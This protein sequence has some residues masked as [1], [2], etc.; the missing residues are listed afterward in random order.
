MLPQVENIREDAYRAFNAQNFRLAIQESVK[1]ITINPCSAWPYFLI[2]LS[3][4]SLG[5]P[6]EAIVYLERYLCLDTARFSQNKQRASRIVKQIKN[7]TDG[8]SKSR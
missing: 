8:F 2:G 1:A 3:L 7:V 4:N 6:H 5:K